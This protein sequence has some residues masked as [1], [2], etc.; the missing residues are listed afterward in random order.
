MNKLIRAAGMLSLGTA[1]LAVQTTVSAA[2]GGDKPW[3][4]SA[5][6]KGFYDDNIYTRP[7][8]PEKIDS[9]GFEVS[10][11]VKYVISTDDTAL[12][13]SYTYSAKYYEGRPSGADKWDQA[14]L[15]NASLKHAFT[16]R[17]SLELSDR[18]A[19]AQE[20]EQLD[21]TGFNF[22][23]KGDNK[24]NHA[25]IA[26]TLGLTEQLSA[27]VGYRNSFFD[28]DDPNYRVALNRIENS[29]SL[30]LRYQLLP[31]TV[32]I[33][34]YSFDDTDY[35]TLVPDRDS[36]SHFIKV[37]VDQKFTPD[38]TASARVGVQI[39][40]YAF[41]GQKDVTSPYADLSVK[42]AFTPDTTLALGVTHQHNATDVLDAQDQ[43]STST[44]IALSHKITSNLTGK[45]LGQFQ[46]SD[47]ISA[48]PLIDGLTED[49]Y[50]VGVNLAYMVTSNI[51]VEAS[52]YY[53]KLT[54]P[55]PGREFSRNRV[56]LGVRFSY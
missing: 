10:P 28:Y 38:L 20:P 9:F 30:D 39:V 1:S 16:P 25:S 44:Y 48:N 55:L 40:D 43:E 52:Y 33:A 27:V 2:D 35:D 7:N 23:A 42:Y 26:A 56:F 36:Q 15:I 54:T 53:D 24:S 6:L 47:F 19:V 14:H 8:G 49:I 18:F 12:K 29:P 51:G 4:L 22:R 34:G 50:S 32:L 46:T 3:S 31:S 45:I 37:G 11:S 5:A 13:L 17:V 41:V 21:S